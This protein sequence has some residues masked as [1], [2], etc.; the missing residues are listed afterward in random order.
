MLVP[1]WLPPVLVVLVVGLLI[2]ALDLGRRDREGAR[3]DDDHWFA[4][5][6]YVN[7][8]DKRIVVPKRYGLGVGRTLNLAH[9]VAW[10][11]LLAPLIVA[12]V[13][14]MGHQR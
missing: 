3:S 11:V 13:G 9:P 4:G 14:F 6:F 12:I 2:A 1:T 10:I 8:D 5:V 7:G